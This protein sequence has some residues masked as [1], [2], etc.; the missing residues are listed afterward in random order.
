MPVRNG[1]GTTEGTNAPTTH[2]IWNSTSYRTNTRPWAPPGVER[3]MS[4]WKASRPNSVD[5]PPSRPNTAR[6][7]RLK[8]ANATNAAAPAT[9]R[10]ARTTAPSRPMADSRGA[11]T[12]PRNVPAIPA[13]I[14][15]PN[16]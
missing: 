14:T 13:A 4:D 12:S 11:M 2:A 15:T 5:A 16:Q 7:G 1:N 6:S 10:D 8:A 9:K 3:C